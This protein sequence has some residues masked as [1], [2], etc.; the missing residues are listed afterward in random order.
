MRAEDL[1]VFFGCAAAAVAA[2]WLVFD[3][4]TALS[5]AF[6]FVVCSVLAFLV[7]LLVGQPAAPRPTGGQRQAAVGGCRHGHSRLGR[8]RSC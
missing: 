4:F 5:G 3:Q 8:S 6:G 1:W 2:V 7:D